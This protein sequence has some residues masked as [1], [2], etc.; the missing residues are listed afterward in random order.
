MKYVIA[1]T[2]MPPKAGMA[3]GIIISDPLPVDVRIGSKAITVVAEVITAGLILRKPASIT[4][5][6]ICGTVL[7]L[8]LAK[9]WSR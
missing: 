2:S 6:R 8:F 3:I 9:L 7:V 1:A 4:A 5:S